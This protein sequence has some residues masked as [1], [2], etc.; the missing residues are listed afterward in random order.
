MSILATTQ[1]QAMHRGGE[2]C[3]GGIKV[4]PAS[5]TRRK[6]SGKA[7]HEGSRSQQNL[8]QLSSHRLCHSLEG[9]DFREHRLLAL[10]G[11][12]VFKPREGGFVFK[13][14]VHILNSA[15]QRMGLLLAAPYRAN[16]LVP[17]YP[18]FFRQTICLQQKLFG[19]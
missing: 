9:R 6:L 15:L 8:P 12:K 5:R 1:C 11:E 10:V 7:Q 2:D 18:L 4:E 16:K 13:K 3:Y 17:Y 19:S 14:E